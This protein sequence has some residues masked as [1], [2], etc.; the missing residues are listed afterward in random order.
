MSLFHSLGRTTVSVQ[1]RGVLCD[2]P[3]QDTFLRWGVI[4]TSPNPQAGGPP[5]VGC[6]R[7]LMQYIRSYPPC[8]RPFLHPQPEDASCRGDWDPPLKALVTW[9]R[10]AFSVKLI[11]CGL[12]HF[13]RIWGEN[14]NR[15]VFFTFVRCIFILSKFYLI[16]NWCTSELSLKKNI[17]IYVKIYNRNEICRSCFSV[18]FNVYYNIVFFSRQL[19]TAADGE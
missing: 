15:Y 11:F 8:W 16:T 14:I 7:L 19:T 12:P 5:Y 3:Q 10:L 17:K 13:C 4:S 9:Y 18:N 6:S 1:V 2:I